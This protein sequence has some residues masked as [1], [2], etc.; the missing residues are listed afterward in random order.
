MINILSKL[1]LPFIAFAPPAI[2]QDA[3]PSRPISVIVPLTA[4]SQ[5]D[6]LA[7]GLVDGLS[8]LTAQ[9]IV[10]INRDGAASTIGVGAVARSKPDGYTLGFG[11][12]GAFVIQPFLRT[13]LNYK[14]DDFEFICQT[15]S[16]LLVFMVGP[17]SPYKSVADLLE[18]GRQ[19]PGKLNFGTV[20]HATSFH[21]LA[22]SISLEAGVKWNHIPFR[23]VGDMVSQTLNG[24]LDFTVSVPNTLNAGGGVIKGLG[25]TGDGKVP[26]LS[27]VPLLR[28][29]G[30]KYSAPPSVIGFYAPKGIPTDALGWLRNA[31]TRAVESPGFIANSTKTLT[32]ITYNESAAYTREVQ[33]GNR[34]IG[35]LI[36][37]L[38]ITAQ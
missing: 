32:G 22:E 9:P 10:V 12:D 27:P 5:L 35:D 29:M 24:T 31:C 19:S 8:K 15:N 33:R 34:E 1:V 23:V 2:C 21:L 7:R 26:N 3:Y 38:N 11:A 13:D 30:Y 36:K 16:T 20:G 4:G 28:D 25:I 18:A 6:I 17:K 37:K 14:V